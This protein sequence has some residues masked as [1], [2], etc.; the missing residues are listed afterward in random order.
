MRPARISIGIG[1]ALVLAAATG[2]TVTRSHANQ[3]AGGFPDLVAGL[4]ATDGC[5]GVETAQ[6]SSGKNVIFAWFEDK[7]AALNWYYSDMHQGVMRQFFPQRTDRKPMQDVPDDAGPIMAIASITFADASQFEETGLPISQIAI[8]LYQPV[9]GG[10][11]LGGRFAPDTVEA[12][13]IR[14]VSPKND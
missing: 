9:T 8:E 10:I 6:T 1:A 3:P 12:K 7:Q 5:L 2:F 4:K 11:Y 13:G 14:N